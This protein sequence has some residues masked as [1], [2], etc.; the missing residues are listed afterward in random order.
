MQSLSG[1]GKQGERRSV[2]QALQAIGQPSQQLEVRKLVRGLAS[3]AEDVRLKGIIGY[4]GDT[5]GRCG[6]AV[7]QEARNAVL[8]FRRIPHTSPALLILGNPRARTTCIDCWTLGLCPTSFQSAGCREKTRGRVVTI[9]HS[10][11]FGEAGT[12]GFTSYFLASAFEKAR[13]FVFTPRFNVTADGCS[14]NC[15]LENALAKRELCK[16]LFHLLSSGPQVYMQPTGML[17]ITGIA[18]EQPFFKK[19]LERWKLRCGLSRSLRGGTVLWIV[20][21]T[22]TSDTGTDPGSIMFW[23]H[24]DSKQNCCR[25]GRM[26]LTGRSTKER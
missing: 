7:A 4:I 19:F 3:A 6:L 23:K 20:A 8:D 26:S 18:T 16:R 24:S 22:L 5:N 1:E 17:S 25:A 12:G 15:D 11:A 13:N 21:L 14:R 10:S 9:A 2:L